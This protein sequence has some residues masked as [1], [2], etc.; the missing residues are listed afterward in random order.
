V[1]RVRCALLWTIPKNGCQLN[2]HLDRKCGQ[3]G[4]QKDIGRVPRVGRVRFGYRRQE[5]HRQQ[6]YEK[7]GRGK[8]GVKEHDRKKANNKDARAALVTS[9]VSALLAQKRARCVLVPAEPNT[10]GLGQTVANAVNEH[11]DKHQFVEST[12]GKDNGHWDQDGIPDDDLRAKPQQR[13]G[14]ILRTIERSKHRHKSRHPFADGFDQNQK[15]RQDKQ[16]PHRDYAHSLVLRKKSVKHERRNKEHKEVN[17]AG[18]VH[19]DVLALDQQP[20]DVGHKSIDQ[21]LNPGT[22]QKGW[23]HLEVTT[24]PVLVGRKI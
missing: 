3:A 19:L 1:R 4:H 21:E 17:L 16:K 2:P 22:Q 24:I 23:I 7:L 18:V 9:G 10:D 13:V 8:A 5:R 20:G 6:R 12:P 11:W 14:P 15:D